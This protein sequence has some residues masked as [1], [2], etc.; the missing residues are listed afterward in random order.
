[1]EKTDKG[2]R[3]CV[4]GRPE[5]E[6]VIPLAALRESVNKAAYTYAPSSR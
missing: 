3:V 2:V 1:V 5:T 4:K 6:E